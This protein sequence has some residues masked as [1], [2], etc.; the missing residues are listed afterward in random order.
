MARIP[1]IRSCGISTLVTGASE[2]AVTVSGYET[3]ICV[4]LLGWIP[5]PD[6]RRRLRDARRR[7]A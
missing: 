7:K 1:R 6:A 2:R 3:L 5:V 4:L